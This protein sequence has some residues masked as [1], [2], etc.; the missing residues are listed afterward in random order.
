MDGPQEHLLN[1]RNQIQ[2]DKY[3]S[4]VSVQVWYSSTL[5]VAFHKRLTAKYTE[6]QPGKHPTTEP[7]TQP[8]NSLPIADDTNLTLCCH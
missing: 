8:L 3:C 5:W 7:Y 6:H 2:K 1:K 4:F